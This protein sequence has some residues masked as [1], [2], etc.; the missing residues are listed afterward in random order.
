MITAKSTKSA[1]IIFTDF[2]PASSSTDRPDAVLIPIPTT[3][4]GEE[5]EMDGTGYRPDN[6]PNA[7]DDMETS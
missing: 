1:P 3:P 5:V 7:D 6:H 2:A 4:R